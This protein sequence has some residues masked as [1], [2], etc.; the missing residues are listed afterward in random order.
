MG[1]R[2]D[3][4]AAFYASQ[5]DKIG[6]VKLWLRENLPFKDWGED[7]F[8]ETKDGYKFYVSDVKWYDSYPDIQ[9]FVSA[10]DM[11]SKMFCDIDPCAVYE[12]VRIG[13]EDDDVEIEREGDYEFRVTVS[14]QICLD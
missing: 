2:S 4:G 10:K 13:E 1:Y 5:E 8:E 7:D 9:R 3:V 12:F 11:F 6:V 14:R